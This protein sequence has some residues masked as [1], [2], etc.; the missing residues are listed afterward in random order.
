M[1]K[2]SSA[3]ATTTSRVVAFERTGDGEK[4]AAR[5]A[6][7]LGQAAIGVPAAG[8]FGLA[9]PN[10]VVQVEIGGGRIGDP[11]DA[12]RERET[13]GDMDAARNA[14]VPDHASG[15]DD[16]LAFRRDHPPKPVSDPEDSCLLRDAHH[17]CA[18]LR[19]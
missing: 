7:L 4:P 3:R 13:P 8:D 16:D 11:A 18:P 5:V 1:V 19:R 14:D 6:D 17:R 9:L 15:A 10:G 2:P 12:G